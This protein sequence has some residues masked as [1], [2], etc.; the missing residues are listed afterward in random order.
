MIKL[1]VWE[2]QFDRCLGTDSF[3]GI[4]QNSDKFESVF[5]NQS[6]TASEKWYS[7]FPRFAVKYYGVSDNDL[8]RSKTLSGLGILIK[9]VP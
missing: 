3:A 9:G 6:E 1:K 4:V 8:I 2:F 7:T 5:L